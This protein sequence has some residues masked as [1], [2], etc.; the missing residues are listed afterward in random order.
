[1]SG[2]ISNCGVF[3]K[4]ILGDKNTLGQDCSSTAAVQLHD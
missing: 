1:M 3:G 4:T 2:I